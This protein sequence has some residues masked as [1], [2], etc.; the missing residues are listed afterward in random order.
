M[1]EELF[2]KIDKRMININHIVFVLK[3]LLTFR[4]YVFL[5]TFCRHKI[6][7]GL[8]LYLDNNYVFSLLH[9]MVSPRT[10][11]RLPVGFQNDL[12]EVVDAFDYIKE[13][14]LNLTSKDLNLIKKKELV[15][16]K[17]FK[18]K[19]PTDLAFRNSLT[20]PEYRR[21]LLPFTRLQETRVAK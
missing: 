3:A 9:E 12:L 19:E 17:D 5:V 7:R 16:S 1:L 6:L 15:K 4:P 10:L 11:L 13:L 14:V 2:K 20:A 8:Y 21:S 18:I